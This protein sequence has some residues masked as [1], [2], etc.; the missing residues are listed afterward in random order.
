[1]TRVITGQAEILALA[2]DPVWSEVWDRQLPSVQDIEAVLGYHHQIVED[3]DDNDDYRVFSILLRTVT[4]RFSFHS[5]TLY[6]N[7]D[8]DHWD[9]T[10]LSVM[11]VLRDINSQDMIN[12]GIT[13][14]IISEF[15]PDYGAPR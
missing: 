4:G 5:C 9:S 6:P 10:D 3:G 2:N 7:S 13:S 11:R 14:D 8:L 12:M 1:M 15:V